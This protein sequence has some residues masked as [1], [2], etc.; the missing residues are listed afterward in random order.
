MK[1]SE[2]VLNGVDLL[3]YNLNKISLNKGEFVNHI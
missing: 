2:F 1:G 3:S